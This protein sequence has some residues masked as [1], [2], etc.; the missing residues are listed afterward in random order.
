MGPDRG[1]RPFIEDVD[2]RL[3]DVIRRVIDVRRIP[4]LKGLF[5]DKSPA[6]GNHPT[7][8]CC[9]TK[10]R[11][12]PCAS[13]ANTDSWVGTG[14]DQPWGITMSGDASIGNTATISYR[15]ISRSDI[16][17]IGITIR[18]S[19]RRRA[20]APTRRPAPRP[21]DGHS[22]GTKTSL[23]LIRT[24]WLLTCEP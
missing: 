2:D 7:S 14:S 10:A 22:I 18:G 13:I 3:R 23:R 24:L 6:Y 5:S 1:I 20:D 16:I 9:N 19:R 12:H 17:G 11:R 8:G 4:Y 15:N 21:A